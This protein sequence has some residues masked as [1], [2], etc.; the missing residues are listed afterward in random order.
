MGKPSDWSL[1][2]CASIGKMVQSSLGRFN[3]S[4]FSYTKAFH[5]HKRFTL[6]SD[7]EFLKIYFQ[8]EYYA[9]DWFGYD[10][11]LDNFNDEILAWRICPYPEGICKLL[12]EYM[13]ISN[14]NMYFLW[15]KKYQHYTE[16]LIFGA[17]KNADDPDKEHYF[18]MNKKMLL[19]RFVRY[20]MDQHSDVI[21][22]AH[23]SM[24][25]AKPKFTSQYDIHFDEYWGK[26]IEDIPALKSSTL[27][28]KIYLF[29]I[30][31]DV[32]LTR[33]EGMLLHAYFNGQSYKEIS[34]SLNTS[35]RTLDSRFNKIKR[36]LNV[37]SKLQLFEV[38]R[39]YKIDELLNNCF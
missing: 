28:D 17:H 10:K 38:M 27:S 12:N 24:Y 23:D 33:E 37:K 8:K 9:C 16:G 19:Q 14:V 5:N 30:Y 4:Y 36:K 29:D 26:Y 13:E 20:F 3:I 31:H 7:P 22:K 6:A 35:V 39:K 21:K 11:A 32:Y 15:Y 2:S 25:T 34:L 18:F 1:K